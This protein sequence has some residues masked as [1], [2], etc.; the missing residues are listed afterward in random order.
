MKNAWRSYGWGCALIVLLTLITYIPAMRGGFVFDDYAL[1]VNDPLIKVSDGLQ[2]FWFTTE[3]TEYYP[4]SW[5]LWWAEWRLWG[6][7]AIGYHVANVLLHSANAILVWIILRHLKIPGA[8]VAGLVFALHPVNVATVAWITEQKN[9][10]SMFFYAVAILSYLRFDEEGSWRWFNLSLAAFLLALLSKTAIVMLPVVL[11]GC[12]W[13]M[14]GRLRVKD[15]LYSVP[16]FALSLIMGLVNVWFEYHRATEGLGVHAT[17]FA[18]RL[19]TAG[20]VPWFY[21]SK[22]L[23]PI[24]LMVV[25]PKWQVNTSNWI[26]YMPGIILIGGLVMFWWK[27]QTWGRSLLFGLGYFVVTLFPVLGFFYQPFYR[28]AF[29]ADH[30]QYYSII[31]V[32]AFMVAAGERI[33][34]RLGEHGLYWGGVGSVAVLLVLGAASWRRGHVYADDVTLWRD[35]VA[36]N[37]APWPYNNLGCALQR[38]GRFN[39]AI[40][41]FDQALRL[42]P[43]YADAHCNRGNVLSQT[44]RTEEAM[45]EWE[46]ALRF[47]PDYAQAHYNLGLGLARQGRLPEAM[48]H[49]E[50]ALRIKPHYAEAH[51]NLGVALE[52]TGKVRE[53][54]GHYEQALRIRPDYEQ[55]RNRLTRLQTVQ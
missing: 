45:A 6:D 14:H 34:R 48:G 52:Q 20:W 9:T 10:M 25:Y 28:H 53:A 26:S 49:W 46:L 42:N 31:G 51:Y 21:L 18:A 3:A 19:A 12:V 30:W 16:F 32:I 43:E 35:N 4:L 27:R 55:A 50:Q 8:L 2:R 29:V 47:K 13:W 24:D 17:G 11:L 38:T 39:E 37:P 22:A 15:F 40:H 33:C 44:G 7:H 41:Q 23:L 1:L 36:R 5:S 54:A